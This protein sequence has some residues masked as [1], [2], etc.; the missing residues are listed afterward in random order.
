MLVFCSQIFKLNY[1]LSTLFLLFFK[2]ETYNSSSNLL[3]INCYIYV[4]FL[5]NFNYLGCV[6]LLTM[7]G[8]FQCTRKEKAN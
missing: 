3:L 2:K 7:E 1:A 4:L 6:C 5:H 8:D